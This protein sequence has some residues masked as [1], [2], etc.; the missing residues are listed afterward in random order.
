VGIEELRPI[1][2]MQLFDPKGQPLEH[3]FEGRFHRPLASSQEHHPFTIGSVRACARF[4]RNL[5]C[6][7]D[8]LIV[9]NWL[10]TSAVKISEPKLAKCL[11]IRTKLGVSRSAQM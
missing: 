5:R 3:L 9:S 8:G 6:T 4:L 7:A 1:I 2:G 11:A 10:S